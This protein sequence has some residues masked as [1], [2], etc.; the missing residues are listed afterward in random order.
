MMRVIISEIIVSSWRWLH[1][2]II[3]QMN[4]LPTE[5]FRFL[6]VGTL[7]TFLSYLLY[8]VLLS[9]LSYLPAY[10][11][12][13]LVGII[14]SYFLNVLFVFKYRLSI[15]TFFKYPIVYIIQYLIGVSM[16]WALVDNVAMSPEFAMISVIVVTIPI[17][18]ITSRFILSKFN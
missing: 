8:L 2:Q 16:L 11:I 18:F 10:T 15:T 1:S 14:L 3:W 13:Y 12:T 9:F 4:R 5:F 7:N 6:L 17:T